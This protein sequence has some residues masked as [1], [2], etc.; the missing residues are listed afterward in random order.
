M[1]SNMPMAII[2]MTVDDPPNET[3]GSVTP[4]YGSEFVTTATLTSA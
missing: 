4:V 1:F 3:S 2:E